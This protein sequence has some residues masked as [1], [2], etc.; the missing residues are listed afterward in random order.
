MKQIFI[1]GRIT[2]VLFPCKVKT[3][4]FMES[5]MWAVLWVSEDMLHFIPETCAKAFPITSQAMQLDK[6]AKSC[7]ID[8]WCDQF[9][10]HTGLLVGTV[11]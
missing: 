9:M 11:S 6:I 2:T 1:I 7:E 3:K 8:G 4:C 10:R 5:R